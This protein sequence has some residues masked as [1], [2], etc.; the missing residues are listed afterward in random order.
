[1]EEN[2]S[3]V[4]RGENPPE[5]VLITY[6]IREFTGEEVKIEIT[7]AA[8]QPV[9]NF[10]VPGTPGLGRINWDLRPTKDVTTEY[11]GLGGKMLFPGGEYTVTLSREKEKEKQKVV[12]TV[13]EKIETR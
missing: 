8:G 4:F 3:A 2:G 13:P 10:K 6:F 11:G 1:V 7:N 5:G 9:A 12:V